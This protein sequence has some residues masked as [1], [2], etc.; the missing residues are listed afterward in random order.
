MFLITKIMH[1]YCRNFGDPREI[2]R[3]LNPL[4]IVS[5]WYTPV[6]ILVCF[7]LLSFK[8]K[9]RRRKAKI[10]FSSYYLPVPLAR[11]PF[12]IILIAASTF[13]NNVFIPVISWSINFPKDL[14][15][16]SRKEGVELLTQLPASY[17]PAFA[18]S[19]SFVCLFSVLWLPLPL[20]ITGHPLKTLRLDASLRKENQCPQISWIWRISSNKIFR[21][22]N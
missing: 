15:L 11:P 16:P 2:G 12:K 22:S 18:Q 5:F 19:F 21:K 4:I 6:N 1:G 17:R 9:R 14:F 10:S 3:K 20:K 13:A 8:K 7:L